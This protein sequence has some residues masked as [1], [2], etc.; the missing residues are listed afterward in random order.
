MILPSA[1]HRPDAIA[2][3]LDGVRMKDWI[4]PFV[5]HNILEWQSNHKGLFRFDWI[6]SESYKSFV[7]KPRNILYG[8]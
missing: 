3:L 4:M 1:P 2:E 8:S 6:S 5:D 7:S